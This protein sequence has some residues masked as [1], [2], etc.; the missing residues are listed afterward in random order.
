MGREELSMVLLVCVCLF[1][2]GAVWKEVASRMPR[3][4]VSQL[5]F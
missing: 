2:V 4:K 5:I 1:L 3:E